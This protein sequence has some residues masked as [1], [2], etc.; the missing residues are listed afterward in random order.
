MVTQKVGFVW[1]IM[2]AALSIRLTLTLNY[3]FGKVYRAVDLNHFQITTNSYNCKD[4]INYAGMDNPV[5]I[6]L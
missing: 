2:K 3:Y 5:I 6:V 4:G 1:S